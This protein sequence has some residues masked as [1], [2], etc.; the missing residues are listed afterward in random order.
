MSG[1]F[2]GAPIALEAWACL[3]VGLGVLA[4]LVWGRRTGWGCGGLVTP[5]LLAL[6]AASPLRILW[7]LLAGLALAPILSLLSRALGLYGRERVGAAMLLSLAACLIL[8]PLLPLLPPLPTLP[9]L[10]AHLWPGWVL[11]GL[12]AADAERQGPVMTVCG[13]VSCAAAASFAVGL[14]RSVL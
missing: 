12:I 8:L 9:S 1:P 2:S 5:G 11:P 6:S 3:T 7:A 4:G 10:P 13:A 14:L